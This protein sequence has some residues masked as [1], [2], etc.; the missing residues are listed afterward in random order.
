MFIW[1]GESLYE[2]STFYI[3]WKVFTL[4]ADRMLQKK[5]SV[6]TAQEYYSELKYI[7]IL[8]IWLLQNTLRPIIIITCIT[9]LPNGE[10][11]GD[12]QCKDIENMQAFKTFTFLKYDVKMSKHNLK[13]SNR[14]HN[15][16]VKIGLTIS[17]ILNK[18]IKLYIFK[19]ERINSQTSR[20]LK[21]NRHDMSSS[22]SS[23]FPFVPHWVSRAMSITFY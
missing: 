20:C 7:Q 8:T 6:S 11:Q 4:K 19:I 9:H 21:K 17:N 10:R 22:T 3:R 2:K 13:C 16:Y 1:N 18:V 12:H 15:K 5:K 23:S 14:T